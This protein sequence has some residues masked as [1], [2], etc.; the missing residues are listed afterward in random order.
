MGGL[1]LAG[2]A[3]IGRLLRFTEHLRKGFPVGVHRGHIGV[4][5]NVGHRFFGRRPAHV[6]VL[7]N[8]R[9]VPDRYIDVDT[10]FYPQMVRDREPFVSFG[11]HKR[12]VVVRAAVSVRFLRYQ[13]VQNFRP[14]R[15]GILVSLGHRVVELL[16]RDVPGLNWWPVPAFQIA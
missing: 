8:V 16:L 1:F 14:L 9:R 12:H 6:S 15:T 11:R 13:S 2:Q 3:G 5:I 10:A 7:G 4:G